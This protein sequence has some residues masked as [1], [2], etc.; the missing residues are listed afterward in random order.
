MIH[1]A[2][3]AVVS[4][5]RPARGVCAAR[6]LFNKRKKANFRRIHRLKTKN[7]VI[8]DFYGFFFFFVLNFL[9]SF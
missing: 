3:K 1:R 4:N 8:C 5:P 7:Y 6:D 9:K 2:L